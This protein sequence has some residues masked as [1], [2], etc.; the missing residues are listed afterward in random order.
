MLTI[1]SQRHLFD[2]PAGIAYF[3]TAYNS[4]LLNSS[5]TALVSAS[6]AKSHPWERPPADFFRDAERIR[7]LAAS[8][9]GGD[10]DGYA[11]VPAASYGLSA[12]ARAVQ[13]TLKAHDRIVVLAEEFPS[14]VLPWRRV[15]L[16]TGAIVAA[17]PTPTDGDWTT[18]TL[19]AIEK[20]AR[21]AALSPCHWTNGARLDLVAIGQA[22]R[23]AG[24]T[25]VLD[26]TQALGAM[27]LDMAAVQPDF[28]VSAGYKWLLCPYGVGL[29]YVADRWRDARP[30]EETW[31]SRVNAADFSALVEYSDIYMPGARRFDVGEKCTAMLP[32]AI[33]ALEQLQAWGV[34]NIARVLGE[35]NDRIAARLEAL[36]FAL[37]PSSHRCPHIVGARVPQGLTGDFVGSL[38]AKQVFISQRGSSIRIAPHLHVTEADVEQQLAALDVVVSSMRSR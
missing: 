5:R 16:E 9:F 35:I 24:T 28:L 38:R 12:A 3:N 7:E 26:A 29:M 19:A 22:C 37:P 31:L 36:G 25:L 2:I 21:V 13:S 17:V 6:H 33:A 23:A 10:A 30:L 27:P 11:V 18:A 14:N 4:P 8:L 20:G 34:G 15:A 1:G 32:G